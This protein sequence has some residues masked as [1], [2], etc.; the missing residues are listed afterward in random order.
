MVALKVTLGERE[1]A[2]MPPRTLTN[3]FPSGGW[4][5]RLG[6]WG[7][8]VGGRAQPKH[9]V[10]VVLCSVLGPLYMHYLK[11]VFVIGFQVESSITFI[12]RAH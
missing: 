6:R 7:G 9:L 8:V 4:V 11:V 5:E 12:Y 2:A 10:L 3:C 1:V